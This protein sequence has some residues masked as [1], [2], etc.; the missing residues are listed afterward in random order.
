MRSLGKYIG[1]NLNE[2]LE[3]AWAIDRITFILIF[4]KKYITMNNLIAS[5][6]PSIVRFV[7]VLSAAAAFTTAH[8][9]EL[10]EISQ[11]FN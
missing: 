5:L 4:T 9:D 7:L 8:A 11:L 1:L 3:V 6:T 2:L 10:K